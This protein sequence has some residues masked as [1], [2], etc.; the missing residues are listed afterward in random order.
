MALHQKLVIGSGAMTFDARQMA[1]RRPPP[2]AVHDHGDVLR[3]PIEVHLPR[4]GLLGGPGGHDGEKIFEGHGEGWKL[5]LDNTG[6]YGLGSRLG[7]AD[8][9]EEQ[10]ARR[11]RPTGLTAIA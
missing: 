10:A 9:G 8:G 3:Q 2:V 5:N 7:I 11:R 1:L 6:S 4:E